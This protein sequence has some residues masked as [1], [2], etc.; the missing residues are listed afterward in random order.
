ML[1][2][3]SL[4]C[5]CGVNPPVIIPA[6]EIRQRKLSFLSLITIF[7][8]LI[9]TERRTMQYPA[10]LCQSCMDAVTARK[11]LS[12]FMQLIGILIIV[13]GVVLTC[14][15]I[16]R[17]SAQPGND[18]AIIS[19]SLPLIALLILGAVALLSGPALGNPQLATLDGETLRFYNPTFQAEFEKLQ[20][21]PLPL[22]AIRP[23][24]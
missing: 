13:G 21:N 7:G 9:I 2:I 12:R 24:L 8:G 4:C 23:A 1:Q 18:A 3:P 20:A 14:P 17:L 16:S 6:F 5:K 22:T 11:R 10:P 19:E 15:N